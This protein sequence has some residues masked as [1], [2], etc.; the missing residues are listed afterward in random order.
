M[1]NA[2]GKRSPQ[3]RAIPGNVPYLPYKKEVAGSNLASPTQKNAFLQ[4]KR[5]T[6]E[7]A[8]VCFA[9]PLLQPD[10]LGFLLGLW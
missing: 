3:G 1:K 6:I 4:V 9:A 10:S 2:L 5:R 7:R 8:G